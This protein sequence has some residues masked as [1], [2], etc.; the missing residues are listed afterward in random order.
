MTFPW[1]SEKE[2]R[3]QERDE[4]YAARAISGYHRTM[5]DIL[6]DQSQVNVLRPAPRRP[7]PEA[8]RAALDAIKEG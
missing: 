4:E 2:R 7:R 5:A 8:A 1:L 6:R 3:K